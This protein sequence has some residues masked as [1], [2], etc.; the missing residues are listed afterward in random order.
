MLN[1]VFIPQINLFIREALPLLVQLDYASTRM[2]VQQRYDPLISFILNHAHA[3]K[4]WLP[5]VAFEMALK[6]LW[7]NFVKVKVMSCSWF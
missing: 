6:K 2:S 7:S 5:E 1:F 4:Q 3:M